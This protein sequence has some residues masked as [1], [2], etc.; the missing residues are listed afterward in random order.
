MTDACTPSTAARRLS[1]RLV[2]GAVLLLAGTALGVSGPAAHASDASVDGGVL[3]YTAGAGEANRLVVEEGLLPGTVV[4]RDAGAALPAEA[5][6]P[7]CVR[8]GEA[9]VCA[10]VVRLVVDLRDRDDVLHNE[11]SLALSALGG[12][13][14]DVLHGGRG[15]DDLHGGQGNDGIAFD[16][17]GGDT[18]YGG[19]GDDRLA[20]GGNLVSGVAARDRL[21]GGDGDDVLI[22]GEVA[23]T[24]S[25]DGPDDLLG[26]PGND[27]LIG[28]TGEDLLDGAAGDDSLSGGDGSD[29]L[30]GGPGADVL[31]GGAGPRDTADYSASAE[32]VVVTVDDAAD[33]GTAGEGDFVRIDVEDVWGGDG[34]DR[35]RGGAAANRLLGGPGAD[36][37]LGGAGDDALDGG[38]GPDELDGEG[39]VDLADYAASATGVDVDLAAGDR[40]RRR[41]ARCRRGRPGRRRSGRAAG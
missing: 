20:G 41:R 30:V 8:E 23:C 11:T 19:A 32:A 10:G 33:D 17:G 39:G 15:P 40:T 24:A 18:L 5:D 12:T 26:G 7:G 35:L 36:V 27:T 4:L 21:E 31:A 6:A 14:S 3:R 9:L 25:C 34:A 13:G 2:I 37:L 22:G 38:A 28:G 29:R 16:D 1:P